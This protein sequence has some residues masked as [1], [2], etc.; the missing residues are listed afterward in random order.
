MPVNATISKLQNKLSWA[1]RSLNDR[2]RAYFQVRIAGSVAILLALLVVQAVNPSYYASFVGFAITLVDIL[3]SFLLRISIS[4]NQ[5]RLMLL[6]SLAG[7]AVIASIGLHFG[8]GV[9][10]TGIGIYLV[11]I[12][13]AALVFLKRSATYWMTLIC[14]V[15]YITLVFFE[16]TQ[17]LPAHNSTFNTIYLAETRLFLANVLLGIVLM[18]I[19]MFLMGGATEVLGNWSIA[20]EDEVNKKSI[21]L[22][23]ALAEQQKTI[24]LLERAYDATLEGWARA[25][26]LRDENT[27]AHIR[28]VT[29]LTVRLAQK[30]NLPESEIV[31]IRRG[32]LLHDIGKIAIP[33]VILFKT[34][35]L[36][37]EEQEV[38]RQHTLNAYEM[39]SSIEYLRPAMSIPYSHHEK[40]DGNGYPEGLQRQQIPLA[41]RIFAIADVYDALTSDRPYRPAWD[42]S[43]ALEH[44][45]SQAGI[46]FDPELVS[47]FLG[48]MN[49][50][51]A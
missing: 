2:A 32:A 25:I 36:S 38:M 50:S 8:G 10:T 33:D 23:I 48:L 40:W 11:L 12:M 35:A 22:Q 41:A 30:A 3:I 37:A 44:I 14:A 34:G 21:A 13:A 29:D 24:N 19:T 5:P 43:R 28:R 17:W 42:K 47:L 9:A 15:C 20:L 31:N 16:L 26:E 7:A 51:E 18:G 4:R 39:L 46:H 49:S 1:S 6:I 45:Q 27:G